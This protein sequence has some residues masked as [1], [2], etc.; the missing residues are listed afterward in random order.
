MTGEWP[1]RDIDHEDGDGL[2]N[3]WRNL[4]LASGTQ[5]QANRPKTAR[6]KTGFKGVSFLKSRKTYFASI[7]INGKSRTLG[8]FA[9][10]EAAARSYDTAALDLFGE[11]ARLNFPVASTGS[12]Q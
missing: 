3:R 11:F 7:K 8:Y 9:S 5:N 2:N 12:A 10:A 1:G 4:R 6:N